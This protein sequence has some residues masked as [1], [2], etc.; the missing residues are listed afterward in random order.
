[1]LDDQNSVSAKRAID[2]SAYGPF[3]LELDPVIN[4]RVLAHA[5]RRRDERFGSFKQTLHRRVIRWLYGIS[6]QTGRFLQDHS[7]LRPLTQ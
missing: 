4:A 3:H 2:A 7:P 1:M 6:L 5:K